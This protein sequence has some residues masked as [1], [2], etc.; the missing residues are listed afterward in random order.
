M[1][2]LRKVISS[3]VI[4]ML[5]V[6][7]LSSGY[8]QE[9]KAI[10]QAFSSSYVSE[11]AGEHTKAIDELKKVYDAQSYEIN[12]RLGWL[13]YQAGLFTE[14]M[15][16]Y[17]KAMALKPFAVEAKL[18]FVYPASAKGNWEM[19]RTRY[20][21]IL[22]IDP[23]NSLVNYRMGLIYYGREE[24]GTALKYFEKVVNLYPFDY[25]GLI[26]YA[27]TNFKLGKYREAK[28]LFNKALMNKPNDSS[29]LE[30]LG[31]IK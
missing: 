26:M 4:G 2:F 14:S 6:A 10:Q 23:Q 20:V 18:G 24:F 22:K 25:D 12:L 1:V 16:Y 5:F 8:S 13:H 30:G 7:T 15:A 31:Y 21:E 19:V 29:A 17:Q 27:W 28:V 11:K 3:L 9:F